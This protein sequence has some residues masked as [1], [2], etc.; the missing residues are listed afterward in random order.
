MEYFI[1]I[2]AFLLSTLGGILLLRI[3]LSLPLKAFLNFALLSISCIG[4]LATEI[5]ETSLLIY[6][7]L[8]FLTPIGI[9][10]RLFAPL[11]L[12]LIG[13]VL[14]KLQHQQYTPLDYDSLMH[15][16]HKMYFCALTFTT[17]KILLYTALVAS[18]LHW[19]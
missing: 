13:R 1:L 16:G 7:L 10:T 5:R 19:I 17:L 8:L 18:F 6:M 15:S 11:I 3:S 4:L 14:S 9:L 2:V 12:N